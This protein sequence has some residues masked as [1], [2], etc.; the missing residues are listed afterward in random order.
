VDDFAY[1]GP[2]YS[3]EKATQ[4]AEQVKVWTQQFNEPKV[5]LVP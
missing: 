3:R 1:R 4:V 2:M 5:I